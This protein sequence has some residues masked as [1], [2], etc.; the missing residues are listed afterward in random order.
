MKD[1]KNYPSHPLQ[2]KNDKKKKNYFYIQSLEKVL[3][4]CLDMLKISDD[5]QITKTAFELIERVTLE[6]LNTYGKWIIAM[7]KIADSCVAN[8]H[9]FSQSEIHDFLTVVVATGIA[10]DKKKTKAV[11]DAIFN[12]YRDIMENYSNSPEGL[13]TNYPQIIVD[14]LSILAIGIDT[15]GEKITAYNIEGYY[16]TRKLKSITAA[17]TAAT[18]DTIK[19]KKD[20]SDTESSYSE[21]PLQQLLLSPYYCQMNEEEKID[22]LKNL[23]QITDRS[24]EA[25]E[26]S[27]ANL[28]NTEDIRT[29][30]DLCANYNKL[31]KYSELL[32]SSED[33]FRF[34]VELQKQL[35][36]TLTDYQLQHAINSI[37]KAKLYIENVLDSRFSPYGSYGINHVKHNLEYGYQL[38]EMMQPNRRR[39]TRR[40][41]V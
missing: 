35:E 6:Q 1:N 2:N 12:I 27:L 11:N 15:E 31:Q 30:R 26:L 24:K 7:K 17:A 39:R 29:L 23:N 19:K 9:T 8:K 13:K 21:T 28:Q 41:F 33:R 5:S 10:D 40:E 25:L 36:R 32:H 38:M 4:D 18:I 16:Q 34:K 22:F 20:Y 14:V 37:K 3:T